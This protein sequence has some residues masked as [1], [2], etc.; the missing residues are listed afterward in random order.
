MILD[1]IDTKILM[2]NFVQEMLNKIDSNNVKIIIN[3]LLKNGIYYAKDLL[4]NSLDLFLLDSNIFIE[5]FETLKKEL[6]E[7]YIEKLGNDISL[8]ELMY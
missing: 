8:I 3:Y 5:K 2:E 6:G 1:E 7:N 4:L